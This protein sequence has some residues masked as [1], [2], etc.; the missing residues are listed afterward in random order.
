MVTQQPPDEPLVNAEL[1]AEHEALKEQTS[2]LFRE[3]QRLHR[4]GGTR[5]EH[6]EHRRKLH[7]KVLELE[8]HSVRLRAR[9]QPR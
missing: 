6:E 2:E 3:H 7:A 5:E 4:T 1:A 9:K 8:E